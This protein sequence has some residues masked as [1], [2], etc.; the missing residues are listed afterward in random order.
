MGIGTAL[1]MIFALAGAGYILLQMTGNAADT[2][3]SSTV[4]RIAQAIATAEG[5]YRAGSRPARNHNPG[6]VQ[7]DL[8]GKAIAMDGPFPVY[9]NDADG[10]ANLYA[11]INLW[12]NGGSAYAGPDSTI[13]DLSEFYT[14]NDQS[15]W[16]VNV[17]NALGVSIDTPIGQIA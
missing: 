14:A 1:T 12:L 7:K 2:S 5:F 10:W 15:S 17:A 13:G 6:D 4:Q 11:Q 9:A 16:A 3:A 8:I